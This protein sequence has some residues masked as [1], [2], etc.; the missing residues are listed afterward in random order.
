MNCSARDHHH[1]TGQIPED[2]PL[3]HGKLCTKQRTKQIFVERDCPINKFSRSTGE[4]FSVR[5]KPKSK[6]LR[7]G[8]YSMSLGSINTKR[9]E[10]SPI[11]DKERILRSKSP[12]LSITMRDPFPS[13]SFSKSLMIS[14]CNN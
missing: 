3:A 4:Y 1:K 8:G 6:R 13:L 2:Y 9:S 10:I 12:W 5:S 7:Q 11:T 14:V